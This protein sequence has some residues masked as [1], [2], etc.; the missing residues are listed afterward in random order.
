MKH[1]L[2]IKN[3]GFTLIEILIYA[4]L[5]TAILSFAILTVY[6]LIDTV[7]RGKNLQEL[8][9]N[10]KLLE[11]KIYWVLQN[12][13]AINS[14][15]AG[16]T[17]TVLSVNKL[18]YG[19]NPVVVD[20]ISETARI[21]IGVGAALPITNDAYVA[22]RDLLFHQLELSGRSAIKVSGELFNAFASTSL[23]I[24]LLIFSEL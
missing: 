20:S 22:V 12:V 11:Q 15:D 19:Q 17:T 5:T 3:N 18:N 13:S 16:A 21:T 4:G 24:D 1:E 8:A 7:D 23:S 2:R 14:P 9:E 10:Q 6:S